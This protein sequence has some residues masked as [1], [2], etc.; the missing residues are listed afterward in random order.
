MQ[1][2]VSLAIYYSTDSNIILSIATNKIRGD[3]N[4]A[5]VHP[6]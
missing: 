5:C 1:A 2:Y 3:K 4:C 6:I